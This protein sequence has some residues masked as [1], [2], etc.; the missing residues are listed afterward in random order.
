RGRTVWN[1]AQD[2]HQKDHIKRALGNERLSGVALKCSQILHT[3]ALSSALEPI[4][5]AGL[6]VNSY[7]LAAG[8]NPLRRR[9]QQASWSRAEFQDPLPRPETHPVKRYSRAGDAIGKAAFQ[10]PG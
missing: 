7:N 9:D 1:L 2:S 4:D 8:Q 10:E 3:G 5:H 6:N